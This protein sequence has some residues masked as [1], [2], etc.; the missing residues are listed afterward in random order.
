MKRIR[1]TLCLLMFWAIATLTLAASAAA[2]TVVV[3]TGNPDLDVPAVQAAVDQGGEVILKGHFSFDN[4]PTVPT[5]ETRGGGA[6]ATSR[7]DP[8]SLCAARTRKSQEL[9]ASLPAGIAVAHRVSVRSS[10]QS[11]S[12]SR[13]AR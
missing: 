5:V 8:V 12:T 1:L 10:Q 2:Q 6:K 7:H 3:G 13:R 9:G 11:Y 4:P